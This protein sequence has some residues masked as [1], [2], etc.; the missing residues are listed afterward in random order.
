[1]AFRVATL[2]AD[3]LPAVRAFNARVAGVAPFPLPET[4]PAAPKGGGLPITWTQYVLLDDDQVRGGMYLMDQPAWAAG[5]ICRAG[6]YQSVLSEAIVDRKY[7][8]VSVRMLKWIER[9]SPLA[10]MVGMGSLER[11]L[12]RLL[13]ASGWTVRPVPFFFRVRNVRAFLRE[14]Q[15]L[16]RSRWWR[17]A[18]RGAAVSGAGWLG[19]RLLQARR[20]LGSGGERGLE[21][22][23]VTAWGACADEIWKQ[24]QP[25]CAFGVI[26]D[27]AALGQLYPLGAGR[28]Q[29][30]VFRHQGQAVGWAAWLDTAM[31]N[32]NY[33]G[34]LRVA[35]VLDCLAAPVHANAVARALTRRLNQ[36]G[37]DL[38]LTNQ[39]HG[40][41]QA[42]FQRA[43][44][45]RATS[46][47][48]LATSKPL[49]AAIAAGGG[50]SLV[51]LTRGDGDGRIHL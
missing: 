33:F 15:P 8:S 2:S 4:L 42:A 25:Q 13:L 46:N 38:L 37:A 50:D 9:Q 28:V 41:W 20:P 39:M 1:M 18:A 31:R 5:Q 21:A 7:N 43:G 45:L 34:N 16:Q 24:F 36:T 23:N 29:A 47:Y 6:N 19:L 26:R 11:P 51:H 3:L 14:A 10:F 32:H 12:P 27:R 49:S 40:V 35:T 48:L 44:F 22:E 30:A 17:A